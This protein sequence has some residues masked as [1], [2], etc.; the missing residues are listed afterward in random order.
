MSLTWENIAC[1]PSVVVLSEVSSLKP[2]SHGRHLLCFKTGNTE[3]SVPIYHMC[4]CTGGPWQR[5]RCCRFLVIYHTRTCTHNP[6]YCALQP[7]R[8]TGNGHVPAGYVYFSAHFCKNGTTHL[9]KHSWL[10]WLFC[11]LC[12]EI[13]IDNLHASVYLSACVPSLIYYLC[14][15]SFSLQWFLKV[16]QKLNTHFIYEFKCSSAKSQ[17]ENESATF[18]ID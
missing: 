1:P 13:L 8:D 2:I 3:N 4:T 17:Q 15:Y 6:C 9:E 11:K 12:F 14:I 5:L 10:A 18:M 7:R 16:D